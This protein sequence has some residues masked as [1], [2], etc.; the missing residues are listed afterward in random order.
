[1]EYRR[2]ALRHLIERALKRNTFTAA[3]PIRVLLL[4][5]DVLLYGMVSHPD[6]IAEAVATVEAV[7]PF[8]RV[9]S[10]LRAH[11]VRTQA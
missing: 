7:A 9:Y 6:L 11:G 1:M 10:C 8:L 4:G 5:E 2:E 3:E